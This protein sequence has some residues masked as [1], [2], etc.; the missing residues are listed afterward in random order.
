[1]SELYAGLKNFE[2][3]YRMHILFKETY[4]SLYHEENMTRITQLALQHEYEQKE[5]IQL[6]E[7]ARQK[8]FRNYSILSL[9][10][11]LVLVIVILNRYHL[12][13]KANPAS[14]L[15]HLLPIPGLEI[16]GHYSP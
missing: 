12:K 9:A 3:A 15:I 6:A 5:L 7:I 10:L 4:D 8:Q 1:M 16:P 11:V 13:R 2:D 14:A